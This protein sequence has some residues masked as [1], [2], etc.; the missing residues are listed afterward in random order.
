MIFIGLVSISTTSCDCRR[1][2]PDYINPGTGGYF[3]MVDERRHQSLQRRRK[4]AIGGDDAIRCGQFRRAVTGGQ[5]SV[6]EQWRRLDA[7]A[8]DHVGAAG[9]EGAAPGGGWGAPAPP[10]QQKKG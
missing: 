5:M 2:C 6:A 10:P 7:A 1:R 4:A 3:P 9:V 8:L